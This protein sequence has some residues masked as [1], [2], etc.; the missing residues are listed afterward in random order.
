VPDEAAEDE[1]VSKG[2]SSQC[3]GAEFEV[4]LRGMGGG[5]RAVLEEARSALHQ[6]GSLVPQ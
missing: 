4:R 6:D 3:V 1:E 5:F 2:G